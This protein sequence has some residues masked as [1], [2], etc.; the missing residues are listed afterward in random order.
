MGSSSCASLSE[1]PELMDMNSMF[2]I[3]IEAFYRKSNFCG[4][5]DT[6]LTERC[7]SSNIRLVGVQNAYSMSFGIWNDVLIEK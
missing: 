7:D 4:R 3:W 5:V 1:I 2:P 6:V